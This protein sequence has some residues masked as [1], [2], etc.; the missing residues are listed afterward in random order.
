MNKHIE[1]SR[2]ASRFRT[3]ALGGVA[4]IALV[5]AGALGSGALVGV[6]STPVIAETSAI[7]AAEPQIITPST[8]TELAKT[9]KPAVVSIQVAGRKARSGVSGDDE[10]DA[11][12]NFRQGSPF[13][14]FFRRFFD[15]DDRFD[16][17][18]RRFGERGQRGE[19]RGNRAM[20]QG[21]GFIISAD[22]YVVTNNHVIDRGEDITVVMDDGKELKAELVG[23]DDRTDLAL[24]KVDGEDLPFVEFTTKAP[25]VGEWVMAVGNPF[26]L[27]GTVTTGVVSASG[28][29][30]GSGPYDDFI[31]IDA[32][33]NRG[34]SGG[35]TF[36]LDGEVIGVNTAIFSPNGGSVGIGFAISADL[37]T[38]VI[39]DLKDDG[40]ITRG[41][42]GVS[43]QD[44]TPE[45]AEGLGLEDA[46]GALVSDVT[47]GSPAEK[48]GLKPGDTV[49][50]VNGKDIESTRDLAR[51]VAGIKPGVEAKLTLWR[52]GARTDTGVEIGTLPARDRLAAMQ[53]GSVPA[54]EPEK[55][56]FEALGLEVEPAGGDDGDGGVVVSSVES[57]SEAA[58]KGFR[59]GDRIVS[60]AG[61]KIDNVADF[62]RALKSA[63]SDGLASVLVLVRSSGGQRFISLKLE[64]A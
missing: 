39:A 57:G 3:R 10:D 63:E 25:L 35:P 9:V 8:F 22:G 47:K 48:A 2:S 55:T 17:F 54:S 64:Q 61:T 43:I 34:N 13:D 32:A 46:A 62:D 18:Q 31:Q 16:Q 14:D 29:V 49:L 50:S 27:G 20:A 58:E 4:A 19:R 45:I 1:S 40:D 52:D 60:V 24:L 36:N 41:W 5:A 11:R 12:P 37:A 59:T 7:R 30:I 21:S 38:E 51:T 56:A 33:V 42:L 6:S 44:V 28:R 26:G 15:N 53:R 23:T